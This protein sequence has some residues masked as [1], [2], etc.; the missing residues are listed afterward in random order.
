MPKFGYVVAALILLALSPSARAQDSTGKPADNHSLET[1][2]PG[3]A[4][5]IAVDEA[6]PKQAA[7]AAQPPAPAAPPVAEQP[8]PPPPPPIVLPPEVNSTISSVVG[9]MDGAEKSL[10]AI[11]N[12]DTD[13]GRLRDDIDG[14]IAKTTQTADSL[15]PRLADIQSQINRLGAPPADTTTAEAPAVAAERTRL[16][17]ESS[18][19][20]GAIKTL[21]LTWYRARQAID[22]ITNLRL[23]LFV[24]S[25]TERMSSPVFPQLWSNALR[26]VPSVSWRLQYNSRDWI[27]SIGRQ[28]G[29]VL[30]LSAI[31]V[32]FYL[33]LKTII[34]AITRYRGAR[35]GPAPTFF[36]RAFSASWIAPAR[37]IPGIATA[38]LV[39]AGLDYLNLLY[40]PTAAPAAT[41]LLK[42]VLIYVAV[43]SLLNAV[44]APW[45]P[46][47]R[48]V[49]LSNRSAGR[50]VRHLKALAAI[51][52]ADLFLSAFG[53]ILY[54]PLSL[55]VVQ[56]LLTSLAFAIALIGLALTPFERLDG[57]GRPYRISE[58]RWIKIPLWL[59]AGAIIFA[60]LLGYVALGRFLA[61]QIVMTGVVGLVA[62]LLYL[63]IRAFTRGTP[64]ERSHMSIVLERQIGFDETR[65]KQFAWLTESV[66][67]LAVAMVAIPVLL[68]Q[69]GFS[70]ADIRDWA[71]SA[72]FG[73]QVGQFN[74]SL[75]RILLG[76]LLF[77][78][79]LFATRLIQGRI[80]DNILVQPRMDPGIANSIDTAIGYA[81]IAVA[82][83]VAISYAGFDITNLA[84]VA[85]AL[86]VGIGLGL[87]SIVNNFVSGLILLIERPIKVGDWIV[88][89]DQQGTVRRISVRSTEIETFDRATLIIPN[90]EFITGRVLNWT[91]RNALGRIVLKFSADLDADPRRIINI[92]TE[93]A[94]NHPDVLREPAPVA[95]FEGATLTTTEYT[96]RVLLPDIHRGLKVQSDLRVAAYEA[97]R[98]PQMVTASRPMA[99]GPGQG[100]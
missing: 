39:F 90:S 31:A 32:G 86:S 30:V 21:E 57:T 89:G 48:L 51:Y 24:K 83:L 94:N 2:L 79:L 6:A 54:F 13:L 66:L 92:L 19:L 85:G 28:K 91:H 70:A 84:I 75:A 80:R 93:C 27:S 45:Q 64:H 52:S 12:V 81:G 88:V 59:A 5:P 16:N 67:T 50:I 17:N 8:P 34:L 97:M 62:T 68:L 36:E 98:R 55:S 49:N 44:F 47:R 33:L 40:Y 74:I 77:V 65:Q 20:S 9:V 56:S 4:L 69:W 95:V 11:G 58:P 1:T 61:Q 100:G 99:V 18:Q 35:T 23:Q 43:A 63:A 42:A 14:V 76:A 10:T 46:E 82:L 96:L 29:Q 53:Q 60:C 3:F 73:F 26:D 37:A 22:K 71:K 7:P 25:L 72:I 15:R 87:Q 78:V 38:F 41:A